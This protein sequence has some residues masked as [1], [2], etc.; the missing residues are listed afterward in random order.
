MTFGEGQGTGRAR[1][2]MLAGDVEEGELEIGQV[3]GM[4]D[5]I[6]TVSDLMR[7][8]ID[9]YDAATIRPATRVD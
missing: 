5:D 3:A 8:M 1:R 2:G 7:T 6:P 9:Q 4:I